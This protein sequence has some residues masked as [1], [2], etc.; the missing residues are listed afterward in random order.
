MSGSLLLMPLGRQEKNIS[1]WRDLAIFDHWVG[2]FTVKNY[3]NTAKHNIFRQTQFDNI[4]LD[5]WKFA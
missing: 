3:G 2:G 5:L 1:V 4:F